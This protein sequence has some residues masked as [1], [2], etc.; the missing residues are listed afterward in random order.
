MILA[1]APAGATPL[2]PDERL[3]LKH[4]HVTTRSKLDELEHVNI[5]EG[6]QWLSRR[7]KEQTLNDDFLRELHKQLFGKV[8]AWAGTYRRTEK[9]IGVDPLQIGVKVRLL[10][11]DALYWAL[12]G[13]YRP[14]EAAARFHHRLVQI[15]PFANGNGRH[16]RIASDCYLERH[17]NHPRIEW[18][19]GFDLQADNARRVSY[20]TALRAAD[21]EDYGPL[22]VFVG[23]RER[24]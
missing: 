15:H 20:I 12:H 14:L 17:F 24:G 4:K 3:G 5:Q 6:L 13:T 2:D 9:N 21:G 8:W 16:A 7:H 18:T 10:T 1:D 11:D 22:L 23:L 19:H